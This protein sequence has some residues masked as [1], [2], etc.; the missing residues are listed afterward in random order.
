MIDACPRIGRKFAP[1]MRKKRAQAEPESHERN[2]ERRREKQVAVG[3]RERD[4]ERVESGRERVPRD[5]GM[6]EERRKQPSQSTAG[7]GNRSR[8]SAEAEGR[9]DK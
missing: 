3:E 9:E 2:R 5:D 1:R 4:G 6:D 8:R 7:K